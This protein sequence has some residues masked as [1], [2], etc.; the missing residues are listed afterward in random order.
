LISSDQFALVAVR[1]KS[2]RLPRKALAEV[3]GKPMI[4]RLVERLAVRIPP[5]QIVLCTSVNA[6]DDDLE[7]VARQ[8]QIQCFRGH[9][10]DVMGRFIAA[11]DRYQAKTIARVTG[12]NPLTDPVM[13]E[14]MFSRHAQEQ[15]EYSFTEDLPVGTRAE[16]LDV[17]ALKRIHKELQDPNYSEY[18]T[19]MLKR[20]D[21]LKQLEIPAPDAV[22]RRPELSLTVDSPEDL[23]LIQDIYAHFGTLLPA[24]EQIIQ[25]LDSVPEKRLFAPPSSDSP[26]AELVV[27]YRNDR[28]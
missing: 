9:E 25:W 1:M 2:T 18:M 11:A 6:Q 5:S 24:L 10:L 26:P 20:P 28:S 21:K 19:F 14:H 17:A 16:V 27:G 3:A 7:D 12:D 22:L 23:A 13:L 4:V 15:S 8:H